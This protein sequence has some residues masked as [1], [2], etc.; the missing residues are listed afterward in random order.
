MARPWWGWRRTW[1]P[2]AA[3]NAGLSGRRAPPSW[4][5][6]IRTACPHRG[7]LRPLLARLRRSVDRR[8]GTADRER[9]RPGGE[10]GRTQRQDRVV[11]RYAARPLPSRSRHPALSGETAGSRFPSCPSAGVARP[12]RRDGGRAR[13]FSHRGCAGVKTWIWSGAS[14]KRDGTCSYVP[15]STGGARRPGPRRPAAPTAAPSTG[16]RRPTLWRR[17]AGAVAPVHVSGWSIAVWA[18]VL[19]RRPAAALAVLAGSVALLGLAAHRAGARSRSRWPPASPAGAR[20][21]PPC[22]PSARRVRAWSPLLVLGLAPPPDPTCLGARARRCPRCATGRRTPVASTRSATPPSTSPTTCPTVRAYGW[23][24][25]V[26]ALVGPLVPRVSWRAR[27]WSARSL[28][29]NLSGGVGRRGRPALIGAG[30]P[31]R[32]RSGTGPRWSSHRRRARARHAGR[33]APSRRACA[34]LA[35]VHEDDPAERA[36]QPDERVGVDAPPPS[37]RWWSRAARTAPR[38]EWTRTCSGRWGFSRARPS[39]A[40]SP[41]AASSDRARSREGTLG[42][43]PRPQRAQRPPGHE[44]AA[45]FG[46]RGHRVHPVPRRAP[47]RPRRQSDRAGAWP[48]RGPG[49]VAHSWARSPPGRCACGRRARRPRRGR[50]GRRSTR[51]NPPVPAPRST[52]VPDVTAGG[53][54]PRRRRAG[55]A[56]SGRSAPRRRRSSR[57]GR[58]APRA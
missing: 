41:P 3:R 4:L 42:V 20:S 49:T 35:S 9:R 58:P 47:R 31:S 46:Q 33:A 57:H 36:E 10:P 18:L 6:S 43:R 8:G 51:D 55:R 1:G 7:W 38:A 26:S 17:H 32:R 19:R 48:R 11:A 28:R 23:A 13:L 5:S 27:V 24:A 44:D 45:H 39:S 37:G 29:E 56:G 40:P 12:S 54:T 2:P 21:G 25:H 16:R 52:T 22:R 50:R 30:G 15:E 53:S 34:R 14:S